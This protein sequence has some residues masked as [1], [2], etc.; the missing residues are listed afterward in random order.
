MCAGNG[1]VPYASYIGSFL[2]RMAPWICVGD[3]T[4]VNKMLKVMCDLL[5]SI[6]FKKQHSDRDVQVWTYSNAILYILAGKWYGQTSIFTGLMLT[7]EKSVN[8]FHTVYWAK[9]K[10]KSVN[11]SSCGAE[12]LACSEADDR[13]FRFKEAIRSITRNEHIKHIL[14]VDSRGLFCMILNSA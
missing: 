8:I 11:H 1:A 12:I 14:Y 2:L 13:A 5:L 7:S 6:V 9:A 3:E 4:E 10:Q